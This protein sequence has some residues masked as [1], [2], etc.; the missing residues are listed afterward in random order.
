VV[1]YSPLAWHELFVGSVG[2]SAALAGLLFVTISMN[3]EHILKYRQLPGRAGATLGVLIC[4]LVVSSFG[5]APGQSTTVLG[6]EI[7]AA[8]AA[9]VTQVLWVSFANYLKTNPL[10]WTVK[11]ISQLC[12][13]GLAFVAGGLSLVVGGGGGLYW[14]LAAIVL[15]FITTSISAWV[16]LVEIL[17]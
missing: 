12:P 16:L 10:A 1:A 3:L 13:P 11:P 14:V 2:A 17:R 8:G 6:I 7:A 4:V 9:V 15:A 5:L